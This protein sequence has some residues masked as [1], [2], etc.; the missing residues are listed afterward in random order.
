M[1]LE[2]EPEPGPESEPE[3]KPELEPQ[4]F[5]SRNWNRNRYHNFS[6]VGTGTVKNCYGSTT[7]AARYSIVAYCTAS[8]SMRDRKLQFCCHVFTIQQ[9]TQNNGKIM[10]M[11]LPLDARCK[12]P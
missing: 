9:A 7:V 8:K 2:P 1:E 4:L 5:K 11:F 12:L 10:D 6:K 3:P